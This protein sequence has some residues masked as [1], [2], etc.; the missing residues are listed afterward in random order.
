MTISLPPVVVADANVILSALIGGRARLVIASAHGPKCVAA[1][2]VAAEISR[3]IPRLAERRG[4]DQALLDAT[5]LVMPIEW[6]TAAEY[7]DQRNEAE[8]RI[9]HRDPDGWP[10]IALALEL[11]LPVW[12]QDKDLTDARLEV[13]TTGDL[14]DALREAGHLE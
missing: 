13:L 2:A 8:T 5:L 4:L 11:G 6:K 1:D 14:L 12:S 7:E 9:A 10:T 3:H